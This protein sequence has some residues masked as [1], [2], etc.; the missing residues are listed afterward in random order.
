MTTIERDPY[1]CV[2]AALGEYTEEA[3]LQQYA[4]GV[5]AQFT[6]CPADRVGPGRHRLVPMRHDVD[7]REIVG[8]DVLGGAPRRH[9]DGLVRHLLRTS[10][11][12]LISALIDIAVVAREITTVVH[13]EH[14]LPK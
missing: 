10:T 4:V 13:S 12:T 5:N 2:D 1:L 14:K 6:Y 11:P 3:P 7:D 8:L 9:G